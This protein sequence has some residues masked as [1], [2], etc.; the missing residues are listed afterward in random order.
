MTLLCISTYI[1]IVSACYPK[2]AK[3]VLTSR[4]LS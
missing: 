1:L 2:F 4:L 3:F